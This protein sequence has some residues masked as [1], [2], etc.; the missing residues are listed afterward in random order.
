MTAVADPVRLLTLTTLFPS[1]ARPR[2][3]I[4]VANRLRR[5][6]ATR[7]ATTRVIAAVPWFPLWYRDEALVL[8]EETIDALPV[9]HPRFL[10][11]PAV[12]MRLQPRLLAE[13]ILRDL[14]KSGWA[15]ER[16]DVVDAHY[17]Y[18][19]AVAARQVADA[20]DLPLVVSARGS[21]I[22][23]LGTFA[24]ARRAILATAQRAQALIAVSQ[25][26]A[27]AM[28]VLGMPAERIGVLRN[29][30]DMDMFRPLARAGARERLALDVRGP[31]LI[32]VGNLV[33]EKGF[34]LLLRAA[35]A[36]PG[37]HVLLIG[38]GREEAVL[39]AL[40]ARLLP[41]RFTRRASMPQREL[42]Y[43][44]AAADALVLPSLREGWPNVLLEA[45]A[46]GTP[47]VAAG[48]G[49]VAEIVVDP[50][51]G[52]IVDG[53]DVGAWTAAIALVLAERTGPERVRACAQPFG[54]DDVIAAQCTLYERV[55]AQWRSARAAPAATTAPARQAE[56]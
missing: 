46:C 44:Y 22:Q 4:F 3:G 34:D 24:A 23:L 35:A 9:R 45:I 47:V 56:G 10:N 19:D 6:C 25:A 49:G 18:P 38:E 1:G 36:M 54:W 27:D 14:T 12:G 39:T 21:D 5:I 48:V 31:L 42:R 32:G 30:V 43:A 50:A 52:R 55:R 15:R 17:F 29:G 2:H 53:R 11:V 28:I 8:E 16:F 37:V 7:R 40:A 20:L 26:L 13:G 41:G 51:A 33:P